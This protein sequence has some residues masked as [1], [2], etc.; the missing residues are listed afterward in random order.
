V[1]AK[2]HALRV[3][4]ASVL[5]DIVTEGYEGVRADAEK[6]FGA[7]R[8]ETGA[9]T[10]DVQLDGTSLGTVSI[11][12]GK[13]T[14]KTDTA[15]VAAIA[16]A[17]HGTVTRLRKEALEDENL[18]A[19]V[20]DQM[21]HL[22]ETTV[23]DEDLKATYKAIDKNGYLKRPDGSKVKVVEAT[24]GEPTGEFR[25]RASAEARA[26][27]LAAWQRGELSELFSEL[28][29]PAIEAGDQT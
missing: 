11:L 28:V 18:L 15:T 2:Q 14:K 22:L 10:L 16:A 25:F 23:R 27:V 5:A 19:F 21:P 20:A 9:K 8:R 13:A 7:A 3:A 24:H 12:A 1:N 29:R 26:A 17:E 6:A 4:A